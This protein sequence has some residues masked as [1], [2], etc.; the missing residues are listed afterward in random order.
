[1]EELNTAIDIKNQ[2]LEDKN[3]T[4]ETLKEEMRMLK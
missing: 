1:M 3:E 4:I 2:M